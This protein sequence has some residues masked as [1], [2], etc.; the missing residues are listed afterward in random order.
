MAAICRYGLTQP[1]NACVSRRRTP[2]RCQ[3]Y[4][5]GLWVP[6]FAGPGRG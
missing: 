1:T 5:A 3:W 6:P 2:D 4:R